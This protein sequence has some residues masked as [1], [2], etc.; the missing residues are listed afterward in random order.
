MFLA[1]NISGPNCVGYLSH[2]GTFT[3]NGFSVTQMLVVISKEVLFP[4]TRDIFRAIISIGQE[5]EVISD[6]VS[7]ELV[8]LPLSSFKREEII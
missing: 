7:H 4:R 3:I 1:H 6:S 2:L 5:N 8:R